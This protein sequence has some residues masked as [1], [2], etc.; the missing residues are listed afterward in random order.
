MSGIPPISCFF[1]VPEYTVNYPQNQPPVV[2][3]TLEDSVSLDFTLEESPN[4]FSN[5][6]SNDSHIHGTAGSIPEEG[7]F[8]FVPDGYVPVLMMDS[9]ASVVE[10]NLPPEAIP[11]NHPVWVPHDYPLPSSLS[12][13]ICPLTGPISTVP[14]VPP[15]TIRKEK[16]TPRPTNAFILFRRENHGRIFQQNPHLS[17]NDVSKTLGKEWKELPE[18]Q[19]EIY[20]QK[21]RSLQQ[22]HQ[23]KYPDYKFT[24]QQNRRKRTKPP[25][26]G[27]N[28]S[29]NGQLPGVVSHLPDTNHNPFH[30]IYIPQV[31][32]T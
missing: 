8:F 31:T 4:F 10:Y 7:E 9:L 6:N 16:K 30:I 25:G 3:R 32:N 2:S 20:R 27:E 11:L 5:F 29:I 21:A 18:N 12:K 19:K 28:D 26:G 17:N 23:A 13:K 22:E 15:K 14:R 1:G 24:P